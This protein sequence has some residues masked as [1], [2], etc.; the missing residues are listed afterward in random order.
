MTDLI[1]LQLDD[2]EYALP[3]VDTLPTLESV[4]HDLDSEFDNDSDLGRLSTSATPTPG[5]A[6]DSSSQSH[7]DSTSASRI[8]SM[9]RHST[10]QSVSKQISSAADRV[11]AGL[12][13]CVAVEQMIAVGTSHGHILCFDNAQVLR[14]C[15]QEFI[16]Q[17]AVSS[18]AFNA[19]N[20]RLLAGF[21]R[22]VIVMID[23]LSGDTLRS[24]SDA[25]TPN[26]GVLSLKW[27]DRPATALCLDSGGSVWSLSFTR[28]LGIRSCESRCLFSG[29]RGEVCAIE[30][31]QLLP[32]DPHPM[33]AHSL[34]AMA[35]LSKFFVVVLRPRL[36]VVKVHAVSG[37][38]DTLPLLS[39]HVV[40]I[41]S[42][43]SSRRVDPVLAAARGNQLFFHQVFVHGNKVNLIPLRHITMG[44]ELLAMKWLGSKH[45]VTCDRSE[46][47]RLI[48]V[49][50]N[51]ELEQYDLCRVGMVYNSAQFKGLAT[52][53]NVS[54]ALALAGTFACYNSVSKIKLFSNHL[55]VTT[56]FQIAALEN[57]L[58]VVGSRSLHV[59]SVRPWSDRISHL[60]SHGKWTEAIS[61]AIEGFRGARDRPMRQE[62]AKNRILQLIEEYMAMTVR[63][64]ENC[65][66][67]VI[68]CLVEIRE[69]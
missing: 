6:T 32:D 30:P 5:G 68:A 2:Q 57:Q 23:T 53:G 16:S 7:H 54:P 13:S 37:P 48:D 36:K 34:V 25:I 49:R 41:E 17:G 62:M 33:K 39:W 60:S 55:T 22:G 19:D 28:R 1:S 66:D 9:L 24:L 12:A 40:L 20:S 61:L 4:L 11:N 50:S 14:W 31:L 47:L 26:T 63:T 43:D 29:A 52:G 27:T 46:V 64:P 59:V 65:L 3:S 42:A 67:A 15:C 69:E 10:L 45:I 35:T 8:G 44:Y 51:K 18:L 58:Y 56:P 38:S 21:A